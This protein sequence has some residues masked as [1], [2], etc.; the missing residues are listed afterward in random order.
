MDQ[1]K[2]KRGFRAHSLV[3]MLSESS[4]AQKNLP[5]SKLFACTSSN[6]HSMAS[7]HALY[8]KEGGNTSKTTPACSNRALPYS[9]KVVTVFCIFFWAAK[10]SILCM[11]EQ[12]RKIL[13]FMFHLS[14]SCVVFKTTA[15][16]HARRTQ[17]C[18]L[19]FTSSFTHVT[20]QASANACATDKS[21]HQY[22]SPVMHS[23]SQPI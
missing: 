10:Q 23:R 8:V 11:H 20:F 9:S 12:K 2:S 19:L 7:K 18:H 1:I 3:H 22:S 21:C 13:L 4:L 15:R 14:H 17:H 5:S 16:I 6:P